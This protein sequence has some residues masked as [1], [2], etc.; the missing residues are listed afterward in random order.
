MYRANH[1]P[2]L[3]LDHRQGPVKASIFRA[4]P[5]GNQPAS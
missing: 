5:I 4:T 1:H 2:A 3:H